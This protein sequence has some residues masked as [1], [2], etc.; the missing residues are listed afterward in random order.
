LFAGFSFLL[1]ESH[2]SRIL[3]DVTLVG[4][5]L[6]GLLVAA[7]AALAFVPAAIWRDILRSNRDALVF[8]IAVGVAAY[9]LGASAWEVWQPLS[10]STF[11]AVRAI[12][13]PLLSTLI[14]NPT[15][16]TIGSPIFSVII[17]PQ[18]SG[19][20]GIGLVFAFAAGW[21]WFLRREWR[22]PHALVLLPAGALA[23]WIFNCFRIA[24]LILIGDAGAPRIALGGFHS[25]AGWVGF[26]AVAIGLCTGA[27]H[28][29]WMT[30][31][32]A[33]PRASESAGPNQGCSLLGAVPGSLGS[34]FD[35][36]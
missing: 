19:Y 29:S 20:E 2:P 18:C 1:F 15:T 27:R 14:Y 33:M 21:L 31:T 9:L 34:R 3:A 32:R 13:Q 25:Q 5:F 23:I 10:H 26:A 6:S 12:L 36:P 17:E 35:Q 4:W 24:A 22:F 8:G 11:V 30:S 28:L 16:L 7:M